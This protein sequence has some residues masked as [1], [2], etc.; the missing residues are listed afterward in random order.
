MGGSIWIYLSGDQTFTNI[1]SP[2]M[3]LPPLGNPVKIHLEPVDVALVSN[4]SIQNTTVCEQMDCKPTVGDTIRY[5]INVD[6]EKDMAQNRTLMYS[7][8]NRSRKRLCMIM[9]YL[10]G[11]VCRD[12]AF[13]LVKSPTPDPKPLK[14]L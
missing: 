5:I 4:M 14:L 1:P 11:L 6:K 2:P 3:S 9:K 13:D 7:R 10:L 8:Q 12:E